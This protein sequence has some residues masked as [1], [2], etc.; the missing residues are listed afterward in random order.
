MYIMYF[1]LIYFPFLFPSSPMVPFLSP[2]DKIIPNRGSRW[3]CMYNM[4]L[5]KSRQLGLLSLIKENLWQPFM[6]AFVLIYKYS[7]PGSWPKLSVI[8][9]TLPVRVDKA[10]NAQEPQ[11]INLAAAAF[12]DPVQSTPCM[13]LVKD[14]SMGSDRL[15]HVTHCYKAVFGSK[16]ML[17]NKPEIMEPFLR[18]G[19]L[20]VLLIGKIWHMLVVVSN[21]SWAQ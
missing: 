4:C 7:S 5:V 19:V 20:Y 6:Q 16:I 13:F 14:N 21:L 9:A 2:S 12:Q 17:R 1:D 10:V 3:Q 18:L 8:T 15:N 11:S